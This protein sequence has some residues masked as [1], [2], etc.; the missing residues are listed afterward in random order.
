MV[1][2]QIQPVC[3]SERKFLNSFFHFE[4]SE[5]MICGIDEGSDVADEV[6]GLFSGKKLEPVGP[7]VSKLSTDT[8]ASGMLNQLF[9]SLLR[10][11]EEF[12]DF[13]ERLDN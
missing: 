10:E 3:V 2:D 8:A 7:V 12:I 13:A 4:R 9:G 5:N 6:D 1:L 11:L